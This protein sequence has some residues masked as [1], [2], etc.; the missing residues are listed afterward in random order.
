MTPTA[1]GYAAIARTFA[2]SILSD[3]KV[4]RRE[5]TRHLLDS[6][7][8]IVAYLARTEP[9]LVADVRAECVR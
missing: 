7:L 4:S 9:R 2:G 8:E 1:E 6:L 3:V 5:D